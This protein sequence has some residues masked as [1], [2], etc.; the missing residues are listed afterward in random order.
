MLCEV[1]SKLDVKLNETVHRYRHAS[2]FYDHDL[3]RS[4]GVPEAF[5]G[6]E[7]GGRLTQT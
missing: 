1:V 7:G 6:E 5:V 4:T 3:K 2:S